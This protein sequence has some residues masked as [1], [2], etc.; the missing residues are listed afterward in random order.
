MNMNK[1]TLFLVVQIK[2]GG[3][4]VTQHSPIAFDAP[5]SP[6]QML[7]KILKLSVMIS[8]KKRIEVNL[9]IQIHS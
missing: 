8:C 6:N 1:I 4:A 3:A 9:I 5:Y 7:I 2:G